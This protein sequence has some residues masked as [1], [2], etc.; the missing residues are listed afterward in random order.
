MRINIHYRHI[1]H[2]NNLSQNI[3]NWMQQQLHIG[4]QANTLHLDI[5][6]SKPTHR[7][8]Q[9]QVFECHIK[10]HAPWLSKEIFVKSS[11]EDFWKALT[12]CGYLLNKQ[13]NR[14]IEHRRSQKRQSKFWYMMSG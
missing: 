2:A 5:F 14:D 9:G 3:T 4:N 13:I 1:T 11:D 6:F 10:A 8:S 12:E 7:N